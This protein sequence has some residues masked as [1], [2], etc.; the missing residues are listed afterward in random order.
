MLSSQL[1]QFVFTKAVRVVDIPDY[2]TSTEKTTCFVYITVPQIPG[3]QTWEKSN[4]LGKDGRGW[5][6]RHGVVGGIRGGIFGTWYCGM[7]LDK[8]CTYLAFRF[9]LYFVTSV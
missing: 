5:E 2:F 6:G 1:T 3:K 4:W 9:G 8:A 7:E